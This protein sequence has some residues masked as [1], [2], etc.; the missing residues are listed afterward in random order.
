MPHYCLPHLSLR[1]L[2]LPPVKQR[3]GLVP[4]SSL[5][6]LLMSANASSTTFPL[7]VSK[8]FVWRRFGLEYYLNA[9]DLNKHRQAKRVKSIPTATDQLTTPNM[10][11]YR[12]NAVTDQ[13]H[14]R[15]HNWTGQHRLPYM[16]ECDPPPSFIMR[17]TSTL[18]S[19]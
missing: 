2:C 18:V 7:Q 5:Y 11:A 15:Q 6:A 10:Y 8:K 3:H 16:G 17:W 19:L 4:L 14:G 12:E 1:Q 9:S 13:L